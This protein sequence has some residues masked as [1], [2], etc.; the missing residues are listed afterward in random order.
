M[1]KTIKYSSLALAITAAL[2]GV[3][4]AQEDWKACGYHRDAINY[5]RWFPIAQNNTWFQTSGGDWNNLVTGSDPWWIIGQFP[6]LNNLPKFKDGRNNVG[7]PTSAV[8]T[9]GGYPTWGAMGNPN[10]VAFRWYSGNC[11]QITETDAF[12]NPAIQNNEL[13]FRKTMVHELGHSITLNHE[14][15]FFAI[16]YSGTWRQ[17][18]KYGSNLYTRNDD[19]VGVR[20]MLDWV[21]G[22]WPGSWFHKNWADMT[23]YNQSHD[24]WGSPGNLIM[25]DLSTYSVPRNGC[26]YIRHLQVENRGR[27][28]AKDVN[29]KVVLSTDTTITAG[30][31]VIWNGGWPGNY[32][33]GQVWANGTLSLIIPGNTPPGSY[34][35][36]WILTTATGELTKGNNADILRRDA[37]GGFAYRKLTVTAQR[38][39][40][41][42]ADFESGQNSP[43][44]CTKWKAFRASLTPRD[45]TKVSMNGSADGVGVSCTTNAK[46]IAAAMRN[47]AVLSWNCGGRTWRTGVCGGGLELSAA[48]SICGCPNPNYIVRPCIGNDNWGGI[49]TAT[50]NPPTQS[51]CVEFV[52]NEP[53]TGACCLPDGSCVEEQTEPEC[54]I[55]EGKWH[56]RKVCR[57]VQCEQPPGRGA[58][59]LPDGSCVENQTREE[60]AAKQGTAWH[61]GKG[62][63]EVECKQPP[64]RGACCLP[65]GSCVEN[66]TKPEC[67]AK[68][69]SEWHEGKSCR[70]ANCPQPT[71]ACCLK[72]G[73]CREALTRAECDAAGGVKWHQ[74]KG[75]R[76]V[77]CEQPTGACCL[78]GGCKENL[79][80]EECAEAEGVWHQG[81]TC[82]EA[83]P[84][85]GCNGNEVI[86]KAKCKTKR[87][88]VKKAIVKLKKATPFTKYMAKLRTGQT[89]DKEANRRG[90][91]T[92]K[93]SAGNKPPCG[94]NGVT[95]S[96]DG[97]DCAVR[98][99]KCD[100]P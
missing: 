45:Y 52:Y 7:V 56:E 43:N 63:R 88:A 38:A 89:V 82:D 58:C 27:L 76:E 48:G 55:S 21:N 97:K 9:A 100:C 8:L 15:R 65:D 64:A 13:Q 91:A 47:G 83:C 57:E 79:T 22:N 67:D 71:G 98:T 81:E 90:K 96:T 95:V 61:E 32:N 28:P 18:P 34:Y 12:A 59:C 77:E 14:D 23:A 37:G 11:A 94:A 93:F 29:F 36:G 4:S 53:K 80:K 5:Y 60:C 62:C 73:S 25:T 40:R 78:D 3:A 66:Q 16:L 85:G 72:D 2:P 33:P 50:C 51:M 54:N 17:P 30:D 31:R 26:L 39:I 68:R 75:C 46:N 84:P 24:N 1:L 41:Y 99:F 74:G 35:V 19:L 87:G 6:N 70:E 44:Q 49:K 92:F 86:S 20:A 42:S 69:G 10:G